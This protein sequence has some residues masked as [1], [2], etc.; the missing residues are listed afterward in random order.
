VVL[1]VVPDRTASVC[2]AAAAAAAVV[3]V[4][5]R[6]SAVAA[7]HVR[8]TCLKCH[9]ISRVCKNQQNCDIIIKFFI[10]IY[11]LLHEIEQ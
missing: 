11:N 8:D 6:R 7:D 3:V 1:A 2:T 10:F 9:W 5:H 4:V